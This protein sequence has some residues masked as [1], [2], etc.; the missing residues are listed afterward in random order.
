MSQFWRC[1]LE[2][3]SVHS[4]S[5]RDL[6][7]QLCRSIRE[8][9][10]VR[11]RRRQCLCRRSTYARVLPRQIQSLRIVRVRSSNTTLGSISLVKTSGWQ[12]DLAGLAVARCMLE[13]IGDSASGPAQPEYMGRLRAHRAP[14]TNAQVCACR[15]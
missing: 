5:P 1:A 4:R 14:G 15:R 3:R 6:K 2:P 7:E 12:R 9:S 11:L 13:H 8:S 10:R